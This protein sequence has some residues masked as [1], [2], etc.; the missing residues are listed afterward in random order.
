MKYMCLYFIESF[1]LLLILNLIEIQIEWFLREEWV[2][3]V[4]YSGLSVFPKGMLQMS[5][6]LATNDENHPGLF[7]VFLNILFHFAF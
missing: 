5:F 3:R 6:A 2:L 4:N 1:F 7:G